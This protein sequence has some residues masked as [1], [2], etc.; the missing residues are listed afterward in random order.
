[1]KYYVSVTETL[2]R[3]VSVE[4][5]SESQAKQKVEHAY[6]ESEI[7][8][9]ENDYVDSSVA[10]EQEDD[11]SFYENVEKQGYTECQHID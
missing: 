7:V 3:V 8:L 9:D 6:A 10:I 2:N 11:Q 5:E 4:A 1:M